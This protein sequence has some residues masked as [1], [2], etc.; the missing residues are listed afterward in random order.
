MSGEV[1]VV[2]KPI[3]KSTRY[4]RQ[5]RLWG[6]KGQASLESAH[7]CLIN[8]S[9][10]GSETLKNLV[11]PGIG[12]ITV[13]DSNKISGKDLG[14]NF[15]VDNESLGEF[16]A[17]RVKDLLLEMNEGVTGEAVTTEVS[18][19]IN[20]QP[21]F[22]KQFTVVIATQLPDSSTL[23]LSRILWSQKV[24]L[25]LLRS[26]G[27]IGYIRVAT[28]EHCI[29]E[30]KPDNA[31]E[32]LRF[33]KPFSELS[34]HADSVDLDKLDKTQHEHVPFL[35]LI[36][37]FLQKWR[38]L[39]EGRFPSKY[40]EKKEVKELIRSGIRTNPETGGPEM[41]DNFDEAI[42]NLNTALTETK[43]PTSVQAILDDPLCSQLSSS[44]SPFWLLAAALKKWVIRSTLSSCSRVSGSYSFCLDSYQLKGTG[45]SHCVGP[46]Q[47]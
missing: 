15:F 37:K 25:I 4:D 45:T 43:I 27:F 21:E 2:P 35:V 19:L 5:L 32:D 6:D 38:E 16:R 24:P 1:P 20:E 26:Y 39:N 7:V 41:E 28:P 11:L 14:Q 22:F 8:A 9:A 12:K 40:K 31:L 33:D 10:V 47:T 29:T 46:F 34:L 30:A 44:S 17:N 3:S 36:Y 23:P 18:L 13:V 42:N